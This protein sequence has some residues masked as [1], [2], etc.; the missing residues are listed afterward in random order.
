MSIKFGLDEDEQAEEDD[1]V[2][3]AIV[4]GVF[5]PNA[6]EGVAVVV[7]VAGDDGVLDGGLIAGAVDEREGSLRCCLPPW[8]WNAST[9]GALDWY[10]GRIDCRP[11][12]IRSG[13]HR[14]CNT[15]EC[16]KL[17]F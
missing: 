9:V 4:I 5:A 8:R 6:V 11:M 14:C 3:P 2:G 12:E 15:L 7:V 10:I 17:I 1:V 16:Y 13:A